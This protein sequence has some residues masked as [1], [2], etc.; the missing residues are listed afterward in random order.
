[1]LCLI[2]RFIRIDQ[3]C[4]AP[5]SRPVNFGA[6]RHRWPKPPTVLLAFD[7]QQVLDNNDPS[8]PDGALLISAGQPVCCAIPDM[9]DNFLFQTQLV[10]SSGHR[11]GWPI[12][13]NCADYRWCPMPKTNVTAGVRDFRAIFS[14]H[15]VTV[16]WKQFMLRV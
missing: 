3:A 9:C 5:H 12:C 13:S 1:M 14:Q 16:N 4:I 6:T 2:C 15:F 7:W 8:P 11:L 10:S